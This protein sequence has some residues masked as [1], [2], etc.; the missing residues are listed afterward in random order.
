[1]TQAAEQAVLPVV[2]RPDLAAVEEDAERDGREPGV[3]GAD[4]LDQGGDPA[5]VVVAV[6]VGDE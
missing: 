3:L 1:M 5:V 2:H 6:G 4:R